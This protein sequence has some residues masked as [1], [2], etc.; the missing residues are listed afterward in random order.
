MATATASSSWRTATLGEFFRIKHGY[1]FKGEFFSES[2]PYILLTPG[3]FNPDGGIKL[4]GE[5]EKYYGGPFPDEF[6]LQRN[7]LLVVVTDLTQ[8][9]SILGSPAFIP[10]SNRFL[11]NQR[12]GKVHEISPNIDRQFLYHLFNSEAVRG[13]IKG[14]ATGAT[15][16]HTAPDRICAVKIPIP[17]LP[18]QCKIAAIL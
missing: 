14:S 2:G 16:R 12:L 6:L 5:N 15:V 7:D 1:A 3:N 18:T 4:K 9:A 11:H 8:T 10:Q 13:Q 17:P